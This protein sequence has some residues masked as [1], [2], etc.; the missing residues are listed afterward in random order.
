MNKTISRIRERAK[1]Y[2]KTIILPESSDVRVVEA[3]KIIKNEGIAQVVLFSA[4]MME[5]N[6]KDAYAKEFY[7][8]RKA[9]GISLEEAKK[10]TAD[11]LYYSAMMVR[12]N[13]ADGFVAGACYTTPEVARAAIYC[14][15]IH[16]D[17]M[18]ASSCFIMIVPDSSWGED[19]VFIFAD[20]GIVPKPT[21]RQLACIAVSSAELAQNVL[22]F[23]P[24]V[25][26]LSYSTKSSGRGK[27]V[28]KVQEATELIHQ[29]KPDLLVDGELQVDAAI[30]P[31]VAQV[32][33]ADS[34]LGGRAN[35]LIFPS[36]NAG[37]I[38]YKLVQRLAKAEA[39]GPLFMGLNRPCSDLSRGCLVDDIVNSVA[40]TAVR[41]QF[42]S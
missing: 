27:T 35:I 11:P 12:H 22:G 30:V 23:Q 29:M 39:I 32:K 17:L 4:D 36:L 15:G 20:C 40:V 3:A 21:S 7:E 37:N 26:L 24:R 18:A 6:L 16:K 19:G 5:D 8:F 9:K 25:A 10:I 1:S 2:P 42:Q 14:L 41:A 33:H 34:I 38:S 13:Q 31:E 28:L